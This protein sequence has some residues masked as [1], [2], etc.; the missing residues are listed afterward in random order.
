LHSSSSFDADVTFPDA[1]LIAVNEELSK[2]SDTRDESGS[3]C[4]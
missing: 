2:A 1:L 3:A 4:T